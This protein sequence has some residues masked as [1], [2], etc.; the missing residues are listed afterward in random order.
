[1][2]ILNGLPI[3]LPEWTYFQRCLQGPG[4]PAMRTSYECSSGCGCPPGHNC[5]V[6][7]W[8]SFDTDGDA[9]IDLADYAIFQEG[10]NDADGG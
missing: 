10:F 1:V 4:R 5:Y 8:A 6:L 9:D 2:A 7:C 3:G